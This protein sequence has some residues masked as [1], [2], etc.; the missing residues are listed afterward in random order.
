MS[1]AGFTGRFPFLFLGCFSLEC[2]KRALQANSHF[3]L[4]GFLCPRGS[5]QVYV[6][7]AFVTGPLVSLLGC[8]WTFVVATGLVAAGA[9]SFAMRRAVRRGEGV[10]VGSL[11]GGKR[12]ARP[13]F[14]FTGRF[15]A[16]RFLRF[17]N[18]R[19]FSGGVRL[20]GGLESVRCFH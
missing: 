12:V 5:S 13:F 7:G 2:P 4:R 1:K 10:C 19:W 8:R 14:F 17:W 6:P 20:L 3:S 15:P 9:F 18:F 16:I 11:P